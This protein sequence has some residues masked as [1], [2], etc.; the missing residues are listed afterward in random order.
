MFRAKPKF[1]MEKIEHSAF[2][3]KQV[4]TKETLDILSWTAGLGDLPGLEIGYANVKVL[5]CPGADLE[6]IE[7]RDAHLMRADF[8]DPDKVAAHI[9]RN[10]T[11]GTRGFRFD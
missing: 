1:V 11:A 9:F 3:R 4:G 8:S 10:Q 7:S 6:L 2:V 5:P